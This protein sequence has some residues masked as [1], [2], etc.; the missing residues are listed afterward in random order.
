VRWFVNLAAGRRAKT[1]RDPAGVDVV[2][3][4]VVL[5]GQQVDTTHVVRLD[6]G[7]AVLGAIARQ[8]GVIPALVL[9]HQLYVLHTDIMHTI[10]TDT[11][12]IGYTL[13]AC[14]G[15]CIIIIIIIIN[16]FV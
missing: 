10:S 4:F 1:D 15:H 9:T 7:V 5:D 8:V 14:S 2:G 6:V 16:R 11:D 12:S 3:A 13:L